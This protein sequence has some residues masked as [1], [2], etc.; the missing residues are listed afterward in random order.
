MPRQPAL[1]INDLIEDGD[2]R[3]GRIHETAAEQLDELARTARV[4][5]RLGSRTY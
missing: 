3:P 1:G 2:F 5:R 4:M